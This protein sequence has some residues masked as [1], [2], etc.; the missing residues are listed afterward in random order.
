MSDGKVPSPED[1]GGDSPVDLMGTGDNV[2]MI[3][4][5]GPFPQENQSVGSIP[6]N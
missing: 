1:E 2:M 4:I 5:D 6:N 3:D